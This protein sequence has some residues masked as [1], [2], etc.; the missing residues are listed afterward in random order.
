M[1][2]FF[3]DFSYLH[4]SFYMIISFPEGEQRPKKERKKIWKKK[5]ALP[6]ITQ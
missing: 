5:K 3:G 1:R 4:F 6:M 2:N